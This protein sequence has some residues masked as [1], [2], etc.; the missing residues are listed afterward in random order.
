MN[1][2]ISNM[3]YTLAFIQNSNP[4][5]IMELGT[6]YRIKD[7]EPEEQH[8]NNIG[9]VSFFVL[10]TYSIKGKGHWSDYQ[11]D[12]IPDGATHWHMSYD[13]PPDDELEDKD[14]KKLVDEARFQALLKKEFPEPT[15]PNLLVESTLRKFYFHD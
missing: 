5:T 8:A 9:Q 7:R 2:N 11:W 13:Q 10:S 12:H 14:T 15:V 1:L 4:A 6:I 3:A